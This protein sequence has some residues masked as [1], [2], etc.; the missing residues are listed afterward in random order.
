MKLLILQSRL[1]D[2]PNLLFVSD[3]RSLSKF[4]STQEFTYIYTY[5]ENYIVSYKHERRNTHG[6]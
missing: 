1:Y 5:I 4:F 3:V 2:M 6:R